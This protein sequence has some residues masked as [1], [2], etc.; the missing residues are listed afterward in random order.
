MSVCG[1]RMLCIPAAV[2]AA[3]TVGS[4]I[5]VADDDGY[6]AQLKKIGVAWQPGGDTTL[7]QLG[8]AI[9]SDRAAGKTPDELAADVHSGLNSSFNYADATAIVS[10]AESNYCP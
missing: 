3:L 5:A 8:H 2:A 9:C 1:L 6:L 10:A 4:G 7:I